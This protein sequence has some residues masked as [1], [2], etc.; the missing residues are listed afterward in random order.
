MIELNGREIPFTYFPDR[1]PS[2]RLAIEDRQEQTLTWLFDGVEEFVVLSYITRHLQAA[3]KSVRL[4]MPYIPNARMDRVKNPDEMFTLKY[5]AEDIN[6]LNFS[7]VIVLDPHSSVSTALINRVRAESPR[8]YINQAVNSIGPLFDVSPIF[9]FPDEGAVKR[10]SDAALPLKH[11]FG[12]K[13]RDWRTGAIQ[14]LKIIGTIPS[15]SPVLI[16]DDICSR[17]GTFVHTAK[18]LKDIGVHNIYL[19]VTHC[20]DTILNGELLSG[21]YVERVFTTNSIFRKNHPLITVY[22]VRE[23]AK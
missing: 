14:G 3:G 6:R 23:V 13:E 12:V 21:G 9:C 19:Y 17:G 7:E 11:V 2:L 4:V 15:D 5:F 22:D 8:N 10:Y 18:T 20:E 16:C 1:T